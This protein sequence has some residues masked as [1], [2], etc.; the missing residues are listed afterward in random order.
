MKKV[1][2]PQKPKKYWVTRRTASYDFNWVSKKVAIDVFMNWV[3]DTLPKGAKDV[4]IGIGEDFY[5]DSN[6]TWLELEWNEK[7]PN[8]RYVSDM[9]KYQKRLKQW[10]EQQCQK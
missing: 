5:Y 10:K 3:K 2:K 6:M 4:T 8:T 7:V 9:K 1:A